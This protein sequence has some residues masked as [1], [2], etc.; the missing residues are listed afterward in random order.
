MSHKLI[1]LAAM[2]LA[3]TVNAQAAQS[4][5]VVSDDAPARTVY[6]L[7][8]DS[9]HVTGCVP[10][11]QCPLTFNPDIKGTYTLRL[12]ALGQN[13]R[14]FAVEQVN[15]T[16]DQSG[17]P[18]K[19]KGSG[20]YT[21]TSSPLGGFHRM[22]LELSVDGAPAVSFTSGQQ[23]DPNTFPSI[24][25]S[26]SDGGTCFF[27]AFDVDSDPAPPKDVTR[28]RLA[29]S[30]YQQGCF[31]PCLCPLLVP[32]EATGTF[33]LVLLEDLGTVANYSITNVSWAVGSPI[34]G[35]FTGTGD[36]TLI[37]GFAGPIHSMD[38]FLDLGD[39]QLA[40]FSSGGLMNTTPGNQI[41]IVVSQTGMVCFDRVFD[42]NAKAVPKP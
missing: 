9:G 27:S 34:G 4:A 41:S 32:I 26:V 17:K 14:T 23:P 29:G 21:R 37:Q 35:V 33:D 16:I 22:D 39:L 28:F 5:F 31:P 40:P 1:G 19:V 36:Y 15:W 20:T 18:R 8:P 2:A 10:P 6:R 3:L 11:C 13:V 42:V 38:L 12:I 30:T 24:D 25:I 7:G